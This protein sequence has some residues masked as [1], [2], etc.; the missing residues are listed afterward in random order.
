MVVCA[1][2]VGGGGLALLG[3]WGVDWWVGVGGCAIDDAGGGWRIAPI[4]WWWQSC[5]GTAV[6]GMRCY[7]V[8]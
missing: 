7:V 8:A 2:V 4:D 1:G 6:H 3:K 5:A